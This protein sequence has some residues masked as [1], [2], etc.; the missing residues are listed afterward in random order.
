MFFKGYEQE[1]FH[2]EDKS[3]QNIEMKNYQSWLFIW[4]F[5]QIIFSLL[6]RVCFGPI[7]RAV[8][9]VYEGDVFLEVLAASDIE[10]AANYSHILSSL[11][12][13]IA[14]V[15]GRMETE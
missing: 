6:R 8:A 7:R 13:H 10:E 11:N 1:A 15:Q 5:N 12:C 2:E 14:I 4:V 3:G 9:E